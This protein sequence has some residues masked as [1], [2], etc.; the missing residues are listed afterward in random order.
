METT[1]QQLRTVG[2]D[3]E[4]WVLPGEAHVLQSTAN[5]VAFFNELDAAR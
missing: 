3:V 5:G 2:G 4:L 1:A